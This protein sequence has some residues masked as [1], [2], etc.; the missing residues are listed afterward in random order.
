M[1]AVN[2]HYIHQYNNFFNQSLHSFVE[3]FLSFMETTQEDTRYFFVGNGASAAVASHLANDFSKALGIKASTFHDPA[4][5]TCFAN[6][7]GYEHWA[8]EAVK[9]YGN[10]EDV[11][12]LI[13]SSG[14]SKNIV[15]AAKTARSKGIK[16]IALTGPHPD[17][18]LIAESDII[19]QIDSQIYNVIECCHMIALC[20]VVD[21]CK[22]ITLQDSS[23]ELAND[24]Q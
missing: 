21:S 18:I 15:N 20:A 1:N 16:V 3:Q 17:P 6:D 9:L 23:L 11:L 4:L 22:M 7:Y 8:A 5:L 14:R 13:S 24:V 12:I 10:P 2:E 19:L